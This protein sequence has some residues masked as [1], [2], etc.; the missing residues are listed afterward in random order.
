MDKFDFSKFFELVFK[1]DMPEI[2]CPTGHNVLNFGCGNS[3][4]PNA[5]N[6]DTYKTLPQIEF[7]DM[8]VIPYTIPS[9]SADAIHCFHALEHTE[10]PLEV[11]QEFARIIKK[12]AP[13]NIAV[14]YWKSQMAY[15]SLDHK[16]FWS[17]ETMKMHLR[18]DYYFAFDNKY[19]LKE[20]FSII[21][22]QEER[23]MVVFIQ[24][25]KDENN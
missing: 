21:C 5:T 11:I 3:L 24:L 12:G 4:I 18:N 13:I 22:G 20:N 16:S 17:E 23:A 25:Y 10:K 19:N 9:D 8:N 6:Y 2:I 7:L 1:M 15:S 14:P